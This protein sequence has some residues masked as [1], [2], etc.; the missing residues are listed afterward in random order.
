[1]RTVGA[2][3]IGQAPRADDL[4]AEIGATLGP[5]YRL[6]E[7]GALDGLG[8]R[9]IAALGPAAGEYVLV[10]L[11]RDGSPVT[12]G[13]TRLLPLL[14]RQ[15]E[16]L[17][18][19][20]VDATLLLCTGEFPRFPSRRPVIRP[21]ETLY[22]LVRGLAGAGGR[23]GVFIPL[24]EQLEQARRQWTA[25]GVEPVL[26]PASP[27]AGSDELAPAAARLAAAGVDVAFLDC[28]GY[29]LAMKRA[30]AAALGRPVVLARSAIARVTAEI[31]E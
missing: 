15:I 17:E 31:V 30:V 18:G 26:E 3:T 12:L 1:V 11:L 10:T 16:A 27:Y 4:V 25:M 6:I 8:R 22:G 5:G 21:Q 7:R 29:S 19:E 23:I 14:Q 28:F 2:L 13:K 20:G 9:E 24:P